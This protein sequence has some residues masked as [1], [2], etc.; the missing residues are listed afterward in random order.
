MKKNLII[1][2]L[3]L[4][5]NTIFA[6]SNKCNIKQIQ[7]ETYDFATSKLEL[8]QKGFSNLDALIQSSI[9]IKDKKIEKITYYLILPENS[10]SGVNKKEITVWDGLHKFIFEKVNSCIKNDSDFENTSMI[11]FR[12]PLSKENIQMAINE[13]N[14]KK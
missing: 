8:V 6:Q 10:Y 3:L 1:P 13:V 2:I 11:V 7:L 12:I 4:L 5:S 9:D 14:S